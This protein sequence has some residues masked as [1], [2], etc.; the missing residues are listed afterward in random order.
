M[1]VTPVVKEAG[2]PEF[3]GATTAVQVGKT[4]WF[5]TYRGDRVAYRAAP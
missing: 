1:K 2:L 3:A 4:L 5:G